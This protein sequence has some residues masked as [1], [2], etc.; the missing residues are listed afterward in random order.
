M[1]A[2]GPNFG[3]DLLESVADLDV[4]LVALPL[5]VLSET[6]AAVW[7]FLVCFVLCVCT[8][9]A[10]AQDVPR[11]ECQALDIWFSSRRIKK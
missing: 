3:C 9:S 5:A 6:Q 4:D 2:L 11:G 10:T 1:N 8:E 7:V